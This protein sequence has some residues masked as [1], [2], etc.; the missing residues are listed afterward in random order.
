MIKL[1][2]IGLGRMGITHYSIINSHPNVE[3]NAIADTSKLVVNIL[4]KYID[5]IT[6]Y[7]NYVDLLNSGLVNAIL[8]CTPPFINYPIISMASSKGIHVFSEKPFVMNSN[9]GKE[10][11]QLFQNKNLVNQVGYVNRY[12]DVFIKTKSLL[13]RKSTRLNSSHIPLSRMPSSA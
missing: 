7:D 6:I 4:D 5:G 3:I 13:D 11:T 1:G 2:I 10:L 9:D 12:N 8:I